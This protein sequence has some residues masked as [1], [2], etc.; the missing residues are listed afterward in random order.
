M[1][2]IQRRFGDL[3]MSEMV[4]R[5]AEAVITANERLDW[6]EAREIARAVIEAMR[7]PTKTMLDG[8]TWYDGPHSQFTPGDAKE[9]WDQMID[10]A[11]K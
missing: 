9:V 11:L 1:L 5:A 4:E 3:G 7:E 6:T 8:P 2:Y 10:A